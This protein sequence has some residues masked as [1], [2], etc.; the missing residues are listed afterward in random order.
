[1][2]V[3]DELKKEV[4]LKTAQFQSFENDVNWFR[5]DQCWAWIRRSDYWNRDSIYW[6]EIDHIIPIA[7][8]WPDYLSNL[9]VLHRKNNLEKSNWRL[10]CSVSSHWNRNIN[11]NNY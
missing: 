8:W 3:S 6:W 2:Y 1:M 10:V 5:K 7:N 9:R 11:I 4:W